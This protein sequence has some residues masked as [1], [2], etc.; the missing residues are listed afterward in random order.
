ML[1]DD[2]GTGDAP[3]RQGALENGSKQTALVGVRANVLIADLGR[4]NHAADD[5][6]GARGAGDA[7]SS[8]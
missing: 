4:I 5:Q 1:V 6:T 2:D 3:R 7:A 8:A